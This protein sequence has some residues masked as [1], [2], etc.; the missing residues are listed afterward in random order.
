M[1]IRIYQI[2]FGRDEKRVSSQGLDEL[3]D[4]QGTTDINSSIYDCVFSGNV[5]CEELED[6]FQ[7]FNKGSDRKS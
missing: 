3:K 2:N 1:K 4:F 7:K 5:E 6:V